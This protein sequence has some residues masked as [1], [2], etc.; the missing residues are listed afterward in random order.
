MAEFDKAVKFVLLNEG[1]LT[2]SENDPGGITNYGISLRFLREVPAEILKRCG[3]FDPIT[4]QTIRELTEDQ[5]KLLYRFCFWETAYFDKLMNQISA[6]YIFDM[7]VQHGI[8]QAIKLVQRAVNACQKTADYL[9]DDGVLGSK[10]VYAINL[11][12]FML[13]SA[14]I[15][16]RECFVR[17]LVEIDPRK[18]RFLHGWIERCYR[19]NGSS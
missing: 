14:F 7:C 5:A 8:S 16:E 1:G 11:A 19:I 10:T 17:M 12:S 15:A 9:K 18:E 13:H 6:N 4:D 2:E 3:I